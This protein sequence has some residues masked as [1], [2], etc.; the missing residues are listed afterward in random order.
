[1]FVSGRRNTFQLFFDNEHSAH[2]L[3]KLYNFFHHSSEKCSWDALSI[4]WN[5]SA[6]STEL[7]P[8]WAQGKLQKQQLNKFPELFL[9]SVKPPCHDV[10]TGSADWSS[11][12]QQRSTDP[13]FLNPEADKHRPHYWSWTD[14]SMWR[15]CSLTSLA[16][17][18]KV[19]RFEDALVLLNEGRGENT[20][21][22]EGEVVSEI[23]RGRFLLRRHRCC[24][25]GKR[26]HENNNIRSNE[27]IS[28]QTVTEHRQRCKLNWCANRLF[29]K[30]SVPGWR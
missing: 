13:H 3:L 18:G 25:V 23:T 10:I 2:S 17:S 20:D 30:T 15:P 28:P 19:R 9:R 6:L 12:N 21:S 14:R 8:V 29:V 7:N 27:L 24:F 22:L 4:F 1:M 26:H 5:K 16:H 11:R